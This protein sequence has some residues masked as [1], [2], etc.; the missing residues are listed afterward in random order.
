MGIVY[1][2]KGGDGKSDKIHLS[3]LNQATLIAAAIRKEATSEVLF[4]QAMS[5][6]NEERAKAGLEPQVAPPSYSTHPASIVHGLR[7]RFIERMNKGIKK[8]LDAAAAVDLASLL[9]ATETPD[10]AP[11]AE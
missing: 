1:S 9:N 3:E 6:H 8:T 11:K 2:Y 4:I 7:T 5:R 10:E